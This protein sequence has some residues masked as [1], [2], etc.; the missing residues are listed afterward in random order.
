MNGKRLGSSWL[1]RMVLF[2]AGIPLLA[3]C[4]TS[5]PITG[6]ADRESAPAAVS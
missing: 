2:A 5:P 3:G 6:P 1:G 4:A